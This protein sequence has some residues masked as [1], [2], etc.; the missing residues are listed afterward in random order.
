MSRT[1]PRPIFGSGRSLESTLVIDKVHLLRKWDEF[2]FLGHRREAAGLPVLLGLLD[3]LLA[4][5]N[6]IPPDVART[7]QRIAAEEHHARRPQRLDRDAVA[8]AED[9][10]ARG[11]MTFVRDLD[12]AFDN[13]DRALLVIGIERHAG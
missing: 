2:M 10:E 7:F 5:G 3:P 8:R 1:L 6:E 13:V 12:L 11:L 4:G 9:Q